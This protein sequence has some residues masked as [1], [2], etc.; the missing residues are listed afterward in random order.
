MCANVSGDVFI[1]DSGVRIMAS[2]GQLLD[3]EVRNVAVNIPHV[4][5]RQGQPSVA[6]REF[7]MAGWA[8]A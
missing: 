6:G 3:T 2:K 7:C 5:S 1:E 8:T 4:P